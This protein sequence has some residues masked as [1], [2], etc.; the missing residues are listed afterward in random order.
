MTSAEAPPQDEAGGVSTASAPSSVPLAVP[1]A[2]R[3]HTGSVSN[4]NK[5]LDA[6]QSGLAA[7]QNQ[8]QAVEASIVGAIAGAQDAVLARIV[9]LLSEAPS[10]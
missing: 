4:I 8:V 6:V 1:D 5:R 3:R 9:S 7:V 10:T 2:K